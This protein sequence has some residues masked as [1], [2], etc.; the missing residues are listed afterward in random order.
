MYYPCWIVGGYL[1]AFTND[2]ITQP[3]CFPTICAP[4]YIINSSSGKKSSAYGAKR[5]VFPYPVFSIPLTYF[6]GL[7]FARYASKP[8][9][10]ARD[11]LDRTPMVL[12]LFFFCSVPI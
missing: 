3:S 5:L 8:Y 9:S 10:G 12:V 7:Y 2:T 6:D 1:H 11:T 4:K